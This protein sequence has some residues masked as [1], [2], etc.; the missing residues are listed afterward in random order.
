[1]VLTLAGAGPGLRDAYFGWISVTAHKS[2]SPSLEDWRIEH[3]AVG[4]IML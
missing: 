1:M 2:G 3:H 4:V